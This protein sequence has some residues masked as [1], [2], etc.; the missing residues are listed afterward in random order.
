M[1][2][3][4]LELRAGDVMIVN[5]AAI[6]FRN[7]TRIELAAR[8][9]FLFGKQIMPPQEATT[10]AKRIYFALQTAYIGTEEERRQGLAEARAL[11]AD[12][13]A[14]TTSPTARAILDEALAAAER[15]ECYLAL[16]LA[17]RIIR[18][19]EAVLGI[20]PAD[21][22]SREARRERPSRPPRSPASRG[23]E[24]AA[25]P[26]GPLVQPASSE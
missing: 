25:E 2:H 9:R 16:R 21:A 8:A 10:P 11:I 15:D 19:E 7:K 12:F 20:G 23:A 13:K 17:R 24:G 3:L 22:A 26:Q 4:V 1:P 6:R 5:G 18:H 14:A